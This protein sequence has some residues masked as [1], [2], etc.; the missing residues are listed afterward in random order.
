MLLRD[1]PM[2]SIE[3]ERGP[4]N[5]IALALG[6]TLLPVT[7]FVQADTSDDCTSDAVRHARELFNQAIANDDFAA[8]ESI[9]AEDVVLVTGTDSGVFK[10]R[11]VQIE[12][13]R[14]D[15]GREDR[16]RYVRRL[17]TVSVSPMHPL[18]LEAGEWTGTAADG[19]EVGGA[20]TAKWRCEAGG[21]ALEAELFMTTRCAGRLCD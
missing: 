20:Y 10:G 1:K 11:A 5:V 3:V 9:L 16:L 12:L 15:V 6:M 21:W 2:R 4:F 19:S 13:W 17:Q 14:S 8:M 7:P 18:A